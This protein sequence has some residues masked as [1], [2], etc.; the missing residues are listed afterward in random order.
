MP[1]GVQQASIEK[2]GYPCRS[3]RIVHQSTC[4]SEV[5]P[6][7]SPLGDRQQGRLHIVAARLAREFRSVPS[8]FQTNRAL[9]PALRGSVSR[10]ASGEPPTPGNSATGQVREEELL[11]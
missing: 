11:A 6:A 4:A 7:P 2:M 9:V 8:T 10:P 5:S 1:S 3:L